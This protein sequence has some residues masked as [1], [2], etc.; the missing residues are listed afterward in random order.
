MR[1]SRCTAIS[2]P[3]SD[4]EFWVERG[5]GVR[6]R[7]VLAALGAEPLATQPPEESTEFRLGGVQFS[8]AYFDPHPDGSY[9]VRGRWSDWVFPPGSF[10]DDYGDL[11]GVR[12]PTMSAAGMLSMKE[13]YP[14]LRNGRR[15]RPK[16]QTDME[17]LRRMT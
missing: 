2:R 16:D 4:I 7:E 6:V 14:L 15:S 9:R 8:I 13:Q 12:V 5:D 3:H 11:E 10:A 1:A 17:L